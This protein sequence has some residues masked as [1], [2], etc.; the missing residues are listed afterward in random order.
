MTVRRFFPLLSLCLLLGLPALAAAQA[1]G[2]AAVGRNLADQK[3]GPTPGLPTCASGAV[4]TGDP[5]KGA[6]IILAK[7]AAGCVIPWHWHT[8]NEH[9][10]LASGAAK[11]EMKDGAPFT[12]RAGGFATMPSKHVHQFTCEQACVL[13]VYSDAP[14]DTHYVNAQGGEITPAEAL[15][16]VKETPGT[17]PK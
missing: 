7:I 16:A 2:G 14:F 1:S 13:Y 4:Q 5:S 11:L 6:S 9:L 3:F 8:P 15:A 17:M 12:L 10:M